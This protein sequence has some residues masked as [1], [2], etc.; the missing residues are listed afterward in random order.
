MTV[1]VHLFARAR[2]LAGSD[3]LKVDL[4]AGATVSDLRQRLSEVC[5][6]LAGF[7]PRC[8]VAVNEDFAADEVTIPADASVAVIPPVSGG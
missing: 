8:A 5:S 7:L 6:A 4:S 1:H 2:D 3:S